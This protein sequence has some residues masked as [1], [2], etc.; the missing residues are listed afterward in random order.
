MQ[1]KLDQFKRLSEIPQ[2]SPVFTIAQKLVDVIKE[3]DITH[4]CNIYTNNKRGLNVYLY[5]N[6][7]HMV[8]SIDLKG[9]IDY[10]Q[11][12]YL[13]KIH[14]ESDL[15]MEQAIQKIKAFKA[16]REQPPV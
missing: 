6:K 10:V 5:A 14:R 8:L 1:R 16:S 13:D 3:L 4:W 11:D 9:Q 15:S 7:F 2:H 12:V